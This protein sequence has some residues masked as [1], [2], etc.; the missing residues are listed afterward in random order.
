MRGS[1]SCRL[2]LIFLSG[3][4]WGTLC[5]CGKKDKT[6]DGWFRDRSGDYVKGLEGPALKVLK[7][8]QTEPFSQDYEIPE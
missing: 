5:A 7:P 1:V 6:Q 4:L 8:A 2:F 3:L